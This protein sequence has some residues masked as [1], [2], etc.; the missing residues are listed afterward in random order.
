[1][2]E[3]LNIPSSFVP[4]SHLTYPYHPICRTS[5]LG[6]S[7][8]A[9]TIAEVI[10]KLPSSL[11][12]AH[13]RQSYFRSCLRIDGNF[14]EKQFQSRVWVSAKLTFPNND[15]GPSKRLQ[16]PNVFFISLNICLEL[17]IP[18]FNIRARG[19]CI[20]AGYMTMPKAAM[21]KDRNPKPA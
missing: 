10:R 4:I 1:M 5:N 20:F 6:A 16:G 7:V 17:S 2:D 18:P 9:I 21:Y 15:Y 8:S 14:L 19:R 13:S 12:T 3:N 11:S